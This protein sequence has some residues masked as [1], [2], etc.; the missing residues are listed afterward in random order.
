MQTIERSSFVKLKSNEVE[1]G[2]NNELRDTI[3]Y[4]LDKPMEA[5]N[6]TQTAKNYIEAN[7][8]MAKGVEKY[9]KLYEEVIKGCIK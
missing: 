6:R 1:Y 3:Q 2:N 5:K 4:I 8:S 7:L 9:E